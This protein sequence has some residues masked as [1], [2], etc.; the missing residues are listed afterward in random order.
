MN[1]YSSVFSTMFRLGSVLYSSQDWIAHPSPKEMGE[2]RHSPKGQT[3]IVKDFSQEEPPR[4]A[5]EKCCRH[6]ENASFLQEKH[7]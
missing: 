6:E 3:G 1:D 4:E 7:L 2:H 5:P